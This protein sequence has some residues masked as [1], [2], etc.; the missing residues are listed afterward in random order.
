MILGIFPLLWM[1]AVHLGNILCVLFYSVMSI[2]VRMCYNQ[3]HITSIMRQYFFFSPYGLLYRLP[4]RKPN[5]LNLCWTDM[6]LFFIWYSDQNCT[7]LYIYLRIQSLLFG[8]AG[9]WKGRRNCDSETTGVFFSHCRNRKHH[10]GCWDSAC[11]PT[12]SEPSAQSSGGRVWGSA[13]WAH[14]T[15]AVHHAVRAAAGTACAGN[16]RAD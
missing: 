4:A 5:T 9:W 1:A 6:L 8:F 7:G 12:A 10:T 11:F 16:F 2:R 15:R 13:F 3:Y 14:E